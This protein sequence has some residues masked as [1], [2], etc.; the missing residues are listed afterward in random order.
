MRDCKNQR[1]FILIVALSGIAALFVLDTAGQLVYFYSV[2]AVFVAFFIYSKYKM[3]QFMQEA[4]VQAERFRAAFSHMANSMFNNVL[5]A[6]ITRDSLLGERCNQLTDLLKIPKASSYSATIEAI[7]D[8]MMQADF[9]AEYKRVL[10]RENILACYAKGQDTIDYE[11]IE[12]SDMVTYI[13]IRIH[14]A[15]FWSEITESLRIVS[16]VKNIDKEKNKMLNLEKRAKSDPM[17]GFYNKIAT[18]EIV[19]QIFNESTEKDKHV[20]IMLDIDDFKKINDTFGHIV[21]DRVIVETAKRVKRLFGLADIIGRVGGDEFLICMKGIKN[22]QEVEARI[23]MFYA[24]FADFCINTA[25]PYPL[26]FSIGI[27]AA[28]GGD[29]FEQAYKHADTALYHVKNN[30]KGN[31]AIY[32]KVEGLRKSQ[33]S[34]VMKLVKLD[35]K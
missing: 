10:S 8:H 32:E 4:Q 27:A 9:S 5:E 6:D 29:L 15:I 25:E 22:M 1:I 17:T 12:R 7:A 23:V 11:C 18:E 24:D 20:I 13:W 33:G 16:Y 35:G 3:Q 2:L 31:Y 26:S 21:G 14:V 19:Q 34:V 30:K 28:Y